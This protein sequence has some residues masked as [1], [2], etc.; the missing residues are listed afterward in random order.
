LRVN[1]TDRQDTIAELKCRLELTE[2]Q[3]E[4]GNNG[5]S[6]RIELR[7]ILNKLVSVKAITGKVA[8]YHYSRIVHQFFDN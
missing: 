2:G 7:D 5:E 4:A 3:I 1:D 6:V 8:K